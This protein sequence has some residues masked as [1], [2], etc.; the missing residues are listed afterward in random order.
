MSVDCMHV[1]VSS[2]QL[3]VDSCVHLLHPVN[4]AQSSDTVSVVPCE[5]HLVADPNT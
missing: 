2:D 1:C 3:H 5:R 4:P